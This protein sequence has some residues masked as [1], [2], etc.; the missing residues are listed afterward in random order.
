MRHLL[1]APFVFAVYN[2]ISRVGGST[3]SY[4]VGRSVILV[5]FHFLVLAQD[6]DPSYKIYNKKTVL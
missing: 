1:F 3:S 4:R 5:L 2:I 6:I